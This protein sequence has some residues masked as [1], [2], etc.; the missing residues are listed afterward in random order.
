MKLAGFVLLGVVLAAAA[1]G[2]EQPADPP[3]ATLGAPAAFDL[4]NDARPRLAVTV[5]LPLYAQP[6]VRA[7]IVERVRSATEVEVLER[8]GG[9]AQVSY[10][11]RQLWLS[12]D[13]DD[14]GFRLEAPGLA[15]ERLAEARRCLRRERR[16]DLGPF[17]LY[18]DVED[19]A[20]LDDLVRLGRQVP[21]A[22]VRRYGVR[23]EPAAAAVVLVAGEEEYLACRHALGAT[24]APSD[25]YLEDGLAVFPV[26][27]REPKLM[28]A[29]LIQHM[30]YLLVAQALGANL[31]DWLRDALAY[32]LA[33]G[34][35]SNDGTF[36]A[37]RLRRKAIHS[38]RYRV[39]GGAY[40]SVPRSADGSAAAPHNMGRATAP[41]AGGDA[42]AWQRPLVRG[43]RGDV[44]RAMRFYD[45]SP[46]RGGGKRPRRAPARLPRKRCS[47]GSGR[48]GGL[49]CGARN[50]SGSARGSGR[51]M[52][53]GD[54]PEA[55]DRSRGE[56]TVAATS[57]PVLGLLIA[58]VPAMPTQ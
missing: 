47:G 19:E 52:D 27:E 11:N 1:F 38:A 5:G 58:L 18:T 28:R 45:A 13:N 14:A 23:P 8:R 54:G 22:F 26:G 2:G 44:A 20:L 57:P 29:R 41:H 42:G 25:G 24:G 40:S 50:D 34:R 31:P 33:Y 39:K 48:R 36:A 3:P 6:S 51:G 15:D 37:E 32:D 56:E 46:P 53:A 4:S 43:R 16:L 7:A 21:E 10:Q 55:P 9:W 12:F 30:A 35:V 49:S 17:P